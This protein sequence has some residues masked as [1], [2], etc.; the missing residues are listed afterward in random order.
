[1]SGARLMRA[2]ARTRHGVAIERVSAADREPASTC[3]ES[4]AETRCESGAGPI[5]LG[6]V[7]E[8]ITFLTAL[9]ERFPELRTAESGERLAKRLDAEREERERGHHGNEA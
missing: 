4:G 2:R 5:D 6:R 9:G 7:R 1:M 3:T 8:V